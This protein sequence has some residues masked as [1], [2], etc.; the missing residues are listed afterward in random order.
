MVFGQLLRLSISSFMLLW[1]VDSRVIPKAVKLTAPGK[2]THRHTLLCKK[3]L[4]ASRILK[5]LPL[6]LSPLSTILSHSRFLLEFPTLVPVT[7]LHLPSFHAILSSLFRVFEHVLWTYIVSTVEH[8]IRWSWRER[9][10]G[11]VSAVWT[12]ES[13]C[14]QEIKSLVRQQSCN[15]NDKLESWISWDH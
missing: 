15:H 14:G 9:L 12:R 8:S 6:F 5:K 7:P 4:P 10:V 2:Y 13:K 1:S 11:S 3:T